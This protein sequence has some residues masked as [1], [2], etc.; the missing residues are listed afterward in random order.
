MSER[1]LFGLVALAFAQLG[2]GR[3]QDAAR[4]Y[5][6]M[7]NV[8]QQ[9]A[10]YTSAG[11]GDLAIY[12]GR[13]SDAV[14]L[15]TAGNSADRKANAPDRAAT[16][17]AAI[18]LAEL[19]RQQNAAAVLAAEDAL[20]NSHSVKIRFLAGRIFAEGGAP[21]RAREM[22]ATLTVELQSEP[23]AY[24]K[25]IE[26]ILAMQAHD[27]RTAVQRLTEATTLLDGWIAHFDLGRAYLLAGAFPQAD[28]EFDRCIKRRGEAL[29]LF[30]DEEPTFAFFP[31]VYYYQGRVKESLKSAKSADA[32]RAYLD[33]RGNSREDALAADARRRVGAR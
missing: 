20:A 33:I 9:G 31:P 24:G 7:G 11:L 23:Q 29:A 19:M 30:L 26:G 3:P 5:V 14:L 27:P 4:T 22:A 8:D 32:Y 17:L 15:L 12:E 1:G 21:A 13:L 28:S 2:Q 18:A 16:K 6:E 10:S 25:I